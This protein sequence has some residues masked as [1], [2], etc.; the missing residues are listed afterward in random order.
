MYDSRIFPSISSVSIFDLWSS[1]N[2]ILLVNTG[3]VTW[4]LDCDWSIQT[5]HHWARGQE[6]ILKRFLILIESGNPEK[7]WT[8]LTDNTAA[9][10]S[11]SKNIVLPFYKEINTLSNKYFERTRQTWPNTGILRKPKFQKIV[12]SDF[13]C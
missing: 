2:G 10:L 3:H 7:S 1:Q 5:S 11:F 9:C 6:I 4:I 13:F 8:M 12:Y